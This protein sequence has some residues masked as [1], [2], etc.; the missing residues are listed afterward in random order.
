M[1]SKITLLLILI[2]VQIFA[3]QFNPSVAALLQ[4]RLDSVQKAQNIQGISTA[5]YYP[6]QGL[7]RGVSGF[8]HPG[9]PVDQDMLFAI[10]SNTKLFTSVSILKLVELGKLKLEDSIGNWFPNHPNINRG[11]RIRQLLNHSSGLRNYSSFPG[12]PD[13]IL[14]NP[15]R[16]YQPSELLKWI[17]PPLFAPGT[18]WEYSNTNYLLAGIIVE[19]VSGISLDSFM[20]TYILQPLGLTHTYFWNETLGYP[21]AHPWEAGRDNSSLPR[22]AIHTAAWAAGG[23]YAQ[24]ADMALWYSGLF[25]RKIIGQDFLDEMTA[26]AGPEDYGL[27]IQLYHPFN[28]PIWGHSGLIKGSFQSQFFYDPAGRFSIAV[29][30]NENGN[31]MPAVIN[32]LLRTLLEN[33][34]LLSSVQNPLSGL[35]PRI[36]PNPGSDFILISTQPSELRE[37]WIMDLQGRKL[38]HC[39]Q[40]ACEVRDLP[41]GCYFIQTLDLSG[42]IQTSLWCKQ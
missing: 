38:L 28:R 35:R 8:S 21:L 2:Q 7:W 20:R 36:S 9:V 14:A 42:Q 27:G 5:I 30:V 24:A 37:A 12:Y 16:V 4:F 41:A 31:F 22:T 29:L 32:T 3:Q 11:I 26:F 6:G 10:G 18:G 15:N 39:P 33:Q 34:S 17:G 23:L 40:S 13:T 1:K 25:D 19:Q